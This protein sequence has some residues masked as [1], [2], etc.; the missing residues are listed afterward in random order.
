[1]EHRV[2]V[3]AEVVSDRAHDAHLG[4]EGRGQRKVHSGTAQHP[5]A[6]TER[7]LHCIESN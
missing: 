7:R 1:M 4:E 2:L 6:L 3:V 5:V